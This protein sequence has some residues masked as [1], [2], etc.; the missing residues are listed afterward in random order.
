MINFTRYLKNFLFLSI[1]NILSYSP[2]D[3]GLKFHLFSFKMNQFGTHQIDLLKGNFIAPVSLAT[4]KRKPNECGW[5]PV[6]I[7]AL[8]TTTSIYLS[9]SCLYRMSWI[10]SSD[11]SDGGTGAPTNQPR[12]QSWYNSMTLCG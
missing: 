7:P 9:V 6:T 4:S 8:S 10:G 12:R 2:P 11:W 3:N 1:Y 5:D